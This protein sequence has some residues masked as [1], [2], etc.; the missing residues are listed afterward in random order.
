MDTL[1]G[2]KY[3]GPTAG[4]SSNIVYSYIKS[5]VVHQYYQAA[6]TYEILTLEGMKGAQETFS[7]R[8][9]TTLLHRVE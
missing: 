3:Q 1:H 4:S 6:S 9:E 8:K 7:F 2:G 5:N